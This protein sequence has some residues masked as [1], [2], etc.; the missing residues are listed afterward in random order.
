MRT[1]NSKRRKQSETEEHQDST[2]EEIE[3][4]SQQG[5]AREYLLDDLIGED[6]SEVTGSEEIREEAIVTN[7]YNKKLDLD[8]YSFLHQLPSKVKDLDKEKRVEI[9]N[10]IISTSHGVWFFRRFIYIPGM[11]REDSRSSFLKIFKKHIKSYDF[12]DECLAGSEIEILKRANK[13]LL[14]DGI[15][16]WEAMRHF[17][18]IND[19]RIRDN[20]RKLVRKLK[21]DV[22]ACRTTHKKFWEFENQEPHIPISSIIGELNEQNHISI[23]FIISLATALMGSI[24]TAII[25]RRKIEMVME[26]LCTGR[27]LKTHIIIGLLGIRYLSVLASI[28]ETDSWEK[29][30]SKGSQVASSEKNS[31]LG[32]ALRI[33]SKWNQEFDATDVQGINSVWFQNFIKKKSKKKAGKHNKTDQEEQEEMNIDTF[34]YPTIKDLE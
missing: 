34:A 5:D 29:P 21:I 23:F 18:S 7:T 28:L 16:C 22:A 15:T 13:H 4:N 26:K 33:A 30:L 10:S 12:N 24:P 32:Y 17:F 14:E 20:L 6:E 9:F 31:S 8:D 11:N 2:Q 19:R 27:T 25:D 1:R 3:Q